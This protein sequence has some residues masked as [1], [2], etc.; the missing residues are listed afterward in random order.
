MAI[1]L[2]QVRMS[3]RGSFA[4]DILLPS[5][6]PVG[7]DIAT[8]TNYTI[9]LSRPAIWAANKKFQLPI[10]D[11]ILVD[12]FDNLGVGQSPLTSHPTKVDG[13]KRWELLLLSEWPHKTHG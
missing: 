4:D 6:P 12:P 1:R 13:Q 7:V 2:R 8:S 11:G 5:L 3:Q 9:D 10:S